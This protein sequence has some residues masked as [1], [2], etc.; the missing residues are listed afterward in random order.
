MSD[1]AKNA[2]EEYEEQIH[3]HT[4]RKKEILETMNVDINTLP[5]YTTPRFRHDL[6]PI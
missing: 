5:E 4:K 1:D 3:T 2:I 6:F